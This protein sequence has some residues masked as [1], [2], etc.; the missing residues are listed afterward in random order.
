[1]PG[2]NSFVGLFFMYRPSWHASYRCSFNHAPTN[3]K[4]KLDAREIEI[5]TV[6]LANCAEAEREQGPCRHW[7]VDS[8][9]GPRDFRRKSPS[10]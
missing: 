7:Q 2:Q 5:A 8:I 4:K 3:Y 6:L 10:R 1:M 9:F